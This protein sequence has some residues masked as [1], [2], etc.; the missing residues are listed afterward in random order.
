[1]LNYINLRVLMFN[2]ML[3]TFLRSV[4]VMHMVN[5]RDKWVAHVLVFGFLQ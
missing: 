2:A 1:M 3:Y 4:E 5:Y